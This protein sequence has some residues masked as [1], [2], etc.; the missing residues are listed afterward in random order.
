M[1]RLFVV[2]AL[3][4]ALQVAAAPSP[5]YGPGNNTSIL[6]KRGSVDLL[7]SETI[8][9]ATNWL[10]FSRTGYC[11]KTQLIN[12]DCGELCQELSDVMVLAMG[13]DG[14]RHPNWHVVY[15]EST[16][17]VVI[18][19]QGTNLKHARSVL[20]DL[21]T[22]QQIMDPSLFIGQR[23]AEETGVKIH[24]GFS[25]VHGMSARQI[26]V[27]V[28]DAISGSLRHPTKGYQIRAKE[29][30]VTG[31]SQG[32]AIAILDAIY[33]RTRLPQD[34]PVRA[35]TVGTPKIGNDAF[36]RM[37]DEVLDPEMNVR[38]VNKHDVIP[39]LPA[40]LIRRG[41]HLRWT[42]CGVEYHVDP[43]GDWWN[44]GTKEN[45]EWG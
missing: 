13:G 28:N 8:D 42:Q 21:H 16:E 15:Q 5:Y 6:S 4:L 1:F 23:F 43:A 45:C 38:I 19:H 17:A 20:I 29:V 25:A 39:R 27:T 44:C 40:K 3:G 22:G 9:E 12:W 2:V 30:V 24:Q 26:Y 37:A 18:V 33:L 7:D 34:I 14:D 32:G 35:V 10:Q 41:H 11:T 31:Y 36:A